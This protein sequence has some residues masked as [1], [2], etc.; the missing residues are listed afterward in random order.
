M[1]GV[2]IRVVGASGRTAM[3]HHRF[4]QFLRYPDLHLKRLLLILLF[5][6]HDARFRIHDPVIIQPTLAYCYHFRARGNRPKTL[7]VELLALRFFLFFLVVVPG[8]REVVWVKPGG[9][10]HFSRI[11]PRQRHPRLRRSGLRAYPYHFYAGLPRALNPSLPIIIVGGKV[12]VG[13]GIE[14]NY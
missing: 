9:S 10:P 2:E 5:T 12:Y 13:V 14:K 1:R 8:A 11:L 4:L 3:E 6:I 7:R